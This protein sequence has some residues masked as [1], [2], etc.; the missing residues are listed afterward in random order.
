[1]R[2]GVPVGLGLQARPFRVV[3]LP[4]GDGL[5]VEVVPGISSSIAAPAVA[6]IPVTMRGL[7]SGVT[8]R[9]VS[10]YPTG[11]SMTRLGRF[12]RSPSLMWA[13]LTRCSTPTE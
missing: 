12:T 11:T 13:L 8:K 1:M 2:G 10:L 4:V 9:A 7:A 6:G 3:E 5:D